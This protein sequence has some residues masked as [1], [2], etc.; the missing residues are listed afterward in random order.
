MTA[1]RILLL[2]PDGPRRRGLTRALSRDGHTVRGVA[3]EEAEEVFADFGPDVVIALSAATGGEREPSTP[4]GWLREAM[5]R[6][7]LRYL[8]CAAPA[9]MEELRQALRE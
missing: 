6:G 5:G 9:N 8:P 3:A 7:A 2:A 1:R 4:S